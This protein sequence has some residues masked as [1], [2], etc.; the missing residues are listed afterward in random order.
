M[1]FIKSIW[2]RE[3]QRILYFGNEFMRNATDH[4]PYVNAEFVKVPQETEAPDVVKNNQVLPM[5]VNRLADGTLS[6]SMDVYDTK[7][8]LITNLDKLQTEYDLRSS[9]LESHTSV[10]RDRIAFDLLAT[11]L[12][13]LPAANIVRT[14][15]AATLETAAGATG[16]RKIVTRKDIS[17]LARVLD[18]QKVPATGRYLLMS[19]DMYY[20]IF[21]DTQLI[22]SMVMGGVSVPTNNLPMV[23]GFKIMVRGGL[24]VFDNAGTPA[25]KALD[26][27]GDYVTAGSD[28]LACIAWHASFVARAEGAIK[29][30]MNLDD[31]TYGGDIFRSQLL[32]G[33]TRL[34]NDAKGIVALVQASAS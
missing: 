30:F 8:T 32:F 18:N 33:G 2:L 21:E 29:V 16:N 3:L 26:N 10:L 14:T 27:D 34:R 7:P 24:P 17:E 22:N 25:V 20:Q 31:A 11:W 28:N 5:T 12:K 4:S 6:Y 19:P 15:G 23:H 9:L 13:N 1:S